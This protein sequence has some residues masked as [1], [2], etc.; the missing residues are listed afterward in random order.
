MAAQ[1]LY[2]YNMPYS[3]RRTL[4]DILDT[5]F[6]WQTLA[7]NIGLTAHEVSQLNMEIHR[8]RGSPTNLLLTNL[9]H[10]NWTTEMLLFYLLRSP[11]LRWAAEALRG[12]VPDSA[13]RD[14]EE[15]AG[16]PITQA[17][18]RSQP[19]MPDISNV[20][21]KLPVPDLDLFPSPPATKAADSVNQ[22]DKTVNCKKCNAHINIAGHPIPLP[23]SQY[24][25]NTSSTNI[26]PNI[27][28]PPAGCYKLP[29]Y[30]DKPAFV[31][32]AK[33]TACSCVDDSQGKKYTVM[34]STK[35]A[36]PRPHPTAVES[37][38]DPTVTVTRVCSD[39]KLPTSVKILPTPDAA[40][41]Q[42]AVMQYQYI[43]VVMATQNFSEQNVIG[44]GGFGVVYHGVLKGTQLAIKR[45]HKVKE[46]SA[47]CMAEIQ[48]L[49][50]YRHKNIITLYGCSL[51]GPHICF[52][53][54]YM[55]NGSLQDRVE[56]RK[57]TPPLS[58][59][60]R[61]SILRDAASGLQ[62]LHTVNS[63]PM[64]H[65]DI[66]SA[67]ILLGV[68]FEAK[69]SD[70]G[71]AKEATGGS[72]V[73]GLKTHVTREQM[74]D[75]YGSLA[76]LPSD[77]LTNGCQYNVKTDVYSFGVVIFETC[78]GLK[79]YDVQ[80][81][82][83]EKL[84]DYINEKSAN[85]ND[86]KLFDLADIRAGRWPD[87]I[88]LR[89]I[90]IARN[91]TSNLKK[92][93]PSMDTV[94]S[95]LEQL[96]RDIADTDPTQPGPDEHATKD[97]HVAP[98]Q[99][100]LPTQTALPP[101]PPGERTKNHDATADCYPYPSYDSHKINLDHQSPKLPKPDLVHKPMNHV[102]TVTQSDTVPPTFY[103]STDHHHQDLK[104]TAI[105]SSK[106]STVSPKFNSNLSDI[107]G[108]DLSEADGLSSLDS[109]LSDERLLN[110]DLPL[111]F[112]NDERVGQE[113]MVKFENDNGELS[114]PHWAM[115]QHHPAVNNVRDVDDRRTVQ[116]AAE[117]FD[118]DDDES[119][120]LLMQKKEKPFPSFF[121]GQLEAL[122]DEATSAVSDKID[123]TA[124][125]AVLVASTRLP[126]SSLEILRPSPP[127]YKQAE[128]PAA[129][130]LAT[131]KLLAPPAILVDGRLPAVAS[132]SP[133]RERKIVGPPSL[134]K[135]DLERI[136]KL[137]WYK[138]SLN[139]EP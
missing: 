1:Q 47:D 87:K 98:P 57:G 89:L 119:Y 64:T 138:A 90:S 74:S 117:C 22:L 28:P 44:R 41:C 36:E 93:R 24:L 2:L 8:A 126:S 56:C 63:A 102:S 66:K 23:A 97:K 5:D 118:D 139:R 135:E 85:G 60:L 40:Q 121:Q 32:P 6:L 11:E 77:V 4:C 50:K 29:P 95:D 51:D 10:R 19:K 128:G 48:T 110:D 78:T 55:N 14:A 129:G 3:K 18:F 84:V 30:S 15:K 37:I 69:I 46:S 16:P 100:K 61:L 53:Y 49:Q 70:F 111:F 94:Q 62:Y 91:C 108:D 113:G 7:G 116:S 20:T 34:A 42:F 26:S 105:K 99:Q 127:V 83:C 72:T 103:A 109:L 79:V 39:H 131:R 21:V 80:R 107:H 33:T 25:V 17:T 38:E 133:E 12:M 101:P 9:G 106:T 81:K 73:T 65:G 54:E 76:Y 104:P 59:P 43:D 71:L 88:W 35:L 120:R 136:S 27:S 124:S 31:P 122:T 68:H 115:A 52:I 96:T 58:V 114:E 82:G 67:N 130:G 45:L 137:E 75:L 134:A 125:P 86:S 123:T 13:F 132:S 92:N 112:S